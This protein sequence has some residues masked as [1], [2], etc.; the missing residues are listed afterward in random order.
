MILSRTLWLDD[1]QLRCSRFDCLD[2]S[3]KEIRWKGIPSWFFGE[4]CPATTV[5]LER[6]DT[7]ILVSAGFAR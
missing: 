6:F 3:T 7:N 1:C 5:T 4:P 2:V